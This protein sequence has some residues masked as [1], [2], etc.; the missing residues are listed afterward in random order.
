MNDIPT[1]D[2]IKLDIADHVATITLNRPD[3][4]NSMPPAMADD[5]R[6]A[7]DYLPLLG[8]S[9]PIRARASTKR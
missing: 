7:L 4:L 5:I 2:T 3:R 9:A 6:S 8:A 1:F